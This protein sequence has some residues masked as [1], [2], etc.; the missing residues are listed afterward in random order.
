MGARV[1]ALLPRSVTKLKP[2]QIRF[3]FDADT[4]GLAHT[5]VQ[6]RRDVTYPGDPGGSSVRGGTGTGRQ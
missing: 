1:R 4:L 2:A 5:I 3:Y 6:L